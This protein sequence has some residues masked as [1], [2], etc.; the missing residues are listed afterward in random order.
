MFERILV[1]LDGSAA[2]EQILPP[3][4]RLLH[5]RAAELVLLRV[6]EAAVLGLAATGARLQEEAESYTRGVAA[7]LA[8][9]GAKVRARVAFGGAA[10]SILDAAREERS[11]LVALATRARDGLSRLGMGSVAEAVIRAAE[12][13]VLVVRTSISP[14]PPSLPIRNVLV[15]LDGS[16]HSRR[17]V[18]FVSEL[19]RPFDAR[20]TLLHVHEPPG[21]HPR[22]SGAGLFLEDVERDLRASTL[23][24][25]AAFRE[26]DPAPEILA[27]CRDRSPDLV[28]MA[29][30]GRSGPARWLLGSVTE[31]VLRSLSIPLLVVPARATADAALPGRRT[32]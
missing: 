22:W 3:L 24:V 27:A 4:Q 2:A 31:S 30:H 12:S 10:S 28:V 9:E 5:G 20:V 32:T 29:T 14:V 23:P 17:V 6:V 11:S 13:P 7:R 21:P 18:P 16:D 1:P 15:P 26:G 19:A 25:E 8:R